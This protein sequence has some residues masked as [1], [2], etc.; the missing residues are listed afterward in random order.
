MLSGQ[1]SFAIG[2]VDGFKYRDLDHGGWLQP[3]PAPVN[4][5]T[6]PA[7]LVADVYKLGL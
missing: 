4:A 1:D 3:A 2:G 6:Q 5:R 7:R